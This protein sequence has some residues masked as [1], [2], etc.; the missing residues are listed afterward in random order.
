MMERIVTE[1]KREYSD[2]IRYTV[3]AFAN[4]EGGK[5]YIGV[6]DDGSVCGVEDCDDTMLRITNMLRDNIR[7][8]VMMFVNCHVE[9][10]QDKKVVVLEVQRG[11][12]RP[13][14]LAKKGIR[15]EGVYIRSGASSIPASESSILKMIQETSGNDYEEE[16]SLNQD[17]TFHT[18]SHYF[19]KKGAAFQ[20][21]QMRSLG[22]IGQDGMYTNAG[23]LLSD[24]C[25]HTVRFSS[26]EGT[27]SV[28]FM[29]EKKQV[30]HC[31]SRW[32]KYMLYWIGGIAHVQNFKV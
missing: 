24:Q 15:P 25:T 23:A 10:M 2:Q 30:V 20:E 16:R 8:D 32:R 19:E 1:W 11:T 17:L 4:T 6:N 31:F 3:V 7:P 13:Y 26:F 28:Y 21:A 18:A 27:R 14:Y 22:L 9:E 5:I 12:H 29:I